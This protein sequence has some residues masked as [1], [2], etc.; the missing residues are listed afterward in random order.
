[1]WK[2]RTLLR[3][4]SV[5]GNRLT[6]SADAS[7][8][9][10]PCVMSNL[11]LRSCRGSCWNGPTAERKIP[12]RE[13]ALATQPTVQSLLISEVTDPARLSGGNAA[14]LDEARAAYRAA[15]ASCR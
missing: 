3:F 6:I 8:P 9:R 1:M 14:I 5:C 11:R 2:S 7:F 15:S 10:R 13:S 4:P 12:M